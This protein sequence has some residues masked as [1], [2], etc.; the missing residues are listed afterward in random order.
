[1]HSAFV[2]PHCTIQKLEQPTCRSGPRSLG[3]RDELDCTLPRPQGH[4]SELATSGSAMCLVIAS[5]TRTVHGQVGELRRRHQVTSQCSPHPPTN[6]PWSSPP[7]KLATWLDGRERLF[8]WATKHGR[9]VVDELSE[10]WPETARVTRRPDQG[11]TCRSDGM[12][13]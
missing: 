3:R 5:I 6:L 4:P 7:R 9:S 1:M 12:K 8:E 10:R 11:A 13:A 2:L